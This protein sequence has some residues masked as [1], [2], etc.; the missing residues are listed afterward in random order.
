MQKGVSSPER[1]QVAPEGR[2]SRQE[3]GGAGLTSDLLTA[4]LGG[5]ESPVTGRMEAGPEAQSAETRGGVCT[6]PFT[7]SSGPISGLLP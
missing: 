3:D 5:S 6:S 7:P 1:T 4:P 2:K